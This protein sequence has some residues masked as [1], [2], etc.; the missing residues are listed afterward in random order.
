MIERMLR[1]SPFFSYL[2][3]LIW[4]RNLSMELNLPFGS[5]WLRQLVLLS[6]RCS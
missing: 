3:S 1:T 2:C 5:L 4:T 6:T